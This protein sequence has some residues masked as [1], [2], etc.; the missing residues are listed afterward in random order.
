MICL[1]LEE[2]ELVIAIAFC[3]VSPHGAE[4]GRGGI[5]DRKQD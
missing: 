3:R 2:L 4:R 1:V 5:I